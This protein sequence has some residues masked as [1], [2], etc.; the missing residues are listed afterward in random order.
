MDTPYEVRVRSKELRKL[1]PHLDLTNVMIA[2]NYC[3]V[4]NFYCRQLKV[5]L[6]RS[7]FSAFMQGGHGPL[8]LSRFVPEIP[9][10]QTSLFCRFAANGPILFSY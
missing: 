3:I 4:F 7:R 2:Y 10:C 1:T 5:P 9:I 6:F 8:V